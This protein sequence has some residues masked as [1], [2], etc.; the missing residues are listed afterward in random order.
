MKFSTDL[1]EKIIC[2]GKKVKFYAVLC[3]F[4]SFAAMMWA[5]FQVLKGH[6]RNFA[7]TSHTIIYKAIT[8]EGTLRI[9]GKAMMYHSSDQ[10]A[11]INDNWHISLASNTQ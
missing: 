11:A 10:E 1:T 9:W 8:D 6:G 3:L 2:R 5:W 4:F 7:H